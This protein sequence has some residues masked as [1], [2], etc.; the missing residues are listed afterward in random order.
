MIKEQ[1]HLDKKFGFFALS[2][3]NTY[4]TLQTYFFAFGWLTDE[5]SKSHRTQKIKYMY[6]NVVHY[7]REPMNGS[8]FLRMTHINT[9]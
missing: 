8:T 4:H 7:C 3:S 6:L 9:E 2:I 5:I 1:K